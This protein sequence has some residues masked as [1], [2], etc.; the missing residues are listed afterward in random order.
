[1][2]QLR[3]DERGSVLVVVAV[4]VPTLMVIMAMA[5]DFGNWWVH[6]RQL[7]NRVDAA[8]L[9]A[10]VAYG[11]LF[12]DCATSPD[13]T[14]AAITN[15]AK[16]YAGVGSSY[17][18]SVNDPA[19]LTVKV[20]ATSLDTA[21]GSAGGPCSAHAADDISPAGSY[22]TEVAAREN[23]VA[24]FFAGFGVPTPTIAARARVA[25][26]RASSASGMRP[27]V[28]ADA[29]AVSCVSATYPNGTVALARVGG[30]TTQWSGTPSFTMPGADA[31]ISIKVGCGSGA[32]SYPQSAYV[33]RVQ[34]SGQQPRLTNI[35]L[36]PAAA[37]SCTNGN[38]YFIPRNGAPCQ[39][40][41]TATVSFANSN[42]QFVRAQVG[43]D[44]PFNLTHGSGND[45][46]G[47]FTVN[48]RTGVGPNG[49]QPVKILARNTANGSYS[50]I[51]EARIQAGT[52]ANQGPI[53][54]VVL[55]NYARATGQ[56]LGQITVTLRGLNPNEVV[57][58]DA[59]ADCGSGNLS[60]QFDNGC[61]GPF[62]IKSG[63]APCRTT[64]PF[65][66]LGGI[67]DGELS[68]LSDGNDNSNYNRRWA[69][70]SSCTA[71]R[72]PSNISPGDPRLVTV[73]L[74]DA[75]PAKQDGNDEYPITG[76]GAFYVTGW[77]GAPSRC[78]GQNDP[79]PDDAASGAVWGHFLK[80][81]LPSANGTAGT[82]PCNPG[83]SA[84]CVAVLVR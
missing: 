50:T 41:V 69:P 37:S 32:P 24:S 56:P 70:G 63:T 48:P 61:S 31:P 58:P 26:M 57:T 84:A 2:R 77:D 73:F 46:S 47:T 51:G 66:C 23:R 67:G 76:F 82:E 12:K 27:F 16:Q 49:A 35:R 43:N 22:W 3:R 29:A 55:Q 59:G 62:Q 74:T 68:T 79:R 45:W 21:D 7:Q 81:V 53:A 60:S 5:I 44:N 9:A 11:T 52:A 36:Q 64:A 19:K 72:W 17:N 34:T 75:L 54:N 14:G 42:N 30:S 10:G 33:T 71:N 15:V 18:A 38:P 25:L 80:L 40:T 28:L 6:K 4:A 65:D 83:D 78:N 39:M 20:N 1:M 8:A 13:A